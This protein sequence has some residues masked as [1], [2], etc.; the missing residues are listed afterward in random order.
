MPLFSG[1]EIPEY[2]CLK[3]IENRHVNEKMQSE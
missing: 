2:I 1:S 3:R